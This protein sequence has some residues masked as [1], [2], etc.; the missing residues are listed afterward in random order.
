MDPQK[1]DEKLFAWCCE[2]IKQG[3]ESVRTPLG[4]R[5]LFSHRAT[6]GPG[7]RVA[8]VGA[9]PAGTENKPTPFS[10]D[11]GNAFAREDILASKVYRREV[12]AM[13][14]AIAG[15]LGVSWRDTLEATL[16]SNLVP[17][18]SPAWPPQPIAVLKPIGVRI[19]N[20]ILSE[21]DLRAIVAD[22]QAANRELLKILKSL[23]YVA[24]KPTT[25]PTGWGPHVFQIHTLSHP[26]RAKVRLYQR[27]HSSWF[28]LFSSSNR[29]KFEAGS[30]QFAADVASWLA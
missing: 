12:L 4:Y 6:L 16:C 10:F 27:P 17:Y 20:R 5:F 26:S 29:V 9:N 8:I 11:D 7:T 19:W 21:L 1:C 28:P 15:A 2:Q 23:E 13:V 22:G 18:R 25:I 30:T 14:E 3:Y 24:D